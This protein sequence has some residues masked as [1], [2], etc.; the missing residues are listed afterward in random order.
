MDTASTTSTHSERATAF[1]L[2]LAAIG[3]AWSG[4]EANLWNGQAAEGYSA[5]NRLTTQS[6]RLASHA[7]AALFH[8]LEIDAL[9]KEK[10]VEAMEESEPALR[11]RIFHSISYLYAG[12]MSERGYGA[13]GLPQGFRGGD[14]KQLEAIPEA[15]LVTAAGKHLD[16]AYNNAMLA[17]ADAAMAQAD[18]RYASARISGGS[19]DHF[20]LAEVIF[21]VSLFFGGIAIVFRDR[22][23]TIG[24]GLA[25]IAAV[26]GY[27]YVGWLPWA[28]I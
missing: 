7:H 14:L 28:W 23:R 20:A 15:D 13:L 27:C 16:E 25:A 9:A 2:G 26:I 19:G 12:Q 6:T 10:T 21:A 18:S 22:L 3:I 4:F 8:D 5:A 1:L 24:L 11:S 17:E